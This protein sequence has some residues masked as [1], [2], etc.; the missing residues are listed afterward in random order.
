MKCMS[1]FG[2]LAEY[3]AVEAIPRQVPAAPLRSNSMLHIAVARGDT[4]RVGELLRQGFPLDLLDTAGFAPAFWALA[5]PDATMLT[6]LLHQGSPVDV[7]S[8]CGDTPLMA[9]VQTGS[10]AKVR[11]LVERGANVNARDNRGFTALH[12]AAESGQAEIVKLLLERGA[13]PSVRA[14]G[15]TA[16]TLAEMR[17]EVEIARLLSSP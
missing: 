9:A 8:A 17:N 5:H 16:Q 10:L 11:I 13:D 1:M 14:N 15:Q 4:A 6:F 2:R 3:A 12:R 7:R